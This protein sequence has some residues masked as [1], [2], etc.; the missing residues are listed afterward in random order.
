MDGM[1]ATPWAIVSL[2]G[3]FLM[4]SL[5]NVGLGIEP[6]WF[7]LIVAMPAFANAMSIFLVPLVGRFLNVREMTLNMAAMNAGIWMSALIGI[8]LLPT[9]NPRM[10]GLFFAGLFG[11]LAATNAV[12]GVGWTSWVV[13]FIPERVRGRYMGRRNFF[14][15][16]STLLFMGVSLVLLAFFEGQRW[17]YVTLAGIAV[18][19]RTVSVF[20]MHR[21]VSPKSEP[22]RLSGKDWFKGIAELRHQKSLLRFI[23]F[24]SVV[25]FSMGFM[26]PVVTVYAFKVLGVTPAW[27]TAY[28]IMATLAGTASVKIW[29]E[30]IDRHGGLPVLIICLVAWRFGD[31][32]WILVTAETKHALFIVWC[33]GGILGTGYMLSMFVL[34]LNFIPS[35]NRSAAVSLNMAVASVFAAVAPVT[36]GFWMKYTASIGWDLGYTSR[37]SIGAGLLLGLLSTVI[38]IGLHEPKTHADR[39]T[40]LGALRTLRQLSVQ[41]GLAFFGNGMFVV[42]KRKR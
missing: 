23:L 2:P 18:L 37:M 11:L 22:T 10:A 42:R 41:Q 30:L 38:L 36:A 24:G 21:I 7:S 27:L 1:L 9:D 34:L 35:D 25:G 5:L 12:A 26:S 17:L 8:A 31:V 39:N 20:L 13:E 32:G 3:S 16:F 4:A 15:N 29:G 14:T 19:G 40:I 33:L 28:S 6:F